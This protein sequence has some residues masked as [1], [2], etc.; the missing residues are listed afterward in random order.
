MKI[1]ITVIFSLIILASCH[2]DQRA[3]VV[4][5]VQK[6]SKLAT[7]EFVI[8]KAV[9]SKKDK[10]FLGLIKLNE[11]YFLAY[12]QAIIKTGIDLQ[13]LKP[14][15]IKISD[16]MIQLKLP[17]VEVI[18]FS[19]PADKFRID[20]GVTKSAFLNHYDIEDYDELFCQAEID[21]RNNLRYMD[22]EKTTQQKTRLLL[23]TLLKN[24]GFEEIYI[25]FTDGLIV[26]DIQPDNSEKK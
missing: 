13:N 26:K 23:E 1:F 8:D 16:K 11:A 2:K 18:N 19:Y 4:S 21:I 9:F 5:K 17:A 22:I 25:E 6:A 15:D 24:L 14:E 10:K 12:S 20:S 3:I 7:C